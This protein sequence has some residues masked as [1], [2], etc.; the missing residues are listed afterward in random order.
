MKHDGKDVDIA[1]LVN[2]LTYK[3]KVDRSLSLIEEAYAKFGDSLVVANS[4]GKDSVAVWH[5][6]KRVNR[7]IRGFII[8]TRY[9]PQ[10]TRD[11]M[12]DQVAKYPEM[13]IFKNDEEIPDHDRRHGNRRRKDAAAVIGAEGALPLLG[14][15]GQRGHAKRENEVRQLV[16]QAEQQLFPAAEPQHTP[17]V[18]QQKQRQHH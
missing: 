4:L 8:T 6:A 18:R 14:P 16:Q 1:A 10:T 3:Q 13:R 12:M 7:N 5:L 15:D 17:V 11:F 9:K 2:E